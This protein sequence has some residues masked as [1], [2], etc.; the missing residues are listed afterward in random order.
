MHSRAVFDVASLWTVGAVSG[1]GAAAVVVGCM[2]ALA[3]RH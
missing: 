3:P 1:V 2:L